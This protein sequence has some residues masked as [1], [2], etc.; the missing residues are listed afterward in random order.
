MQKY[1]VTRLVSLIPTLLLVTILVFLL[2]RLVPGSIV[3]TMLGTEV[4]ASP[5]KYEEMRRFFGLDQ[6]VTIQYFSWMGNVLTGDLGESWRTGESVLDLILSSLQVTALLTIGSMLIALIIGIPFGIISALRENS[7][8]DHVVR[9]VSLLSLSI[10]IFWQAAMI[11]LV[12]SLWLHI[13]PPIGF[14]SPMT[15]PL[16]SLQMMLVPCAVLG[17]GVSATIMRVT[18]SS[19]LDTLREDYVRTARAKG[20]QERAVVWIHV[21]KNAMIPIITIAGLQI[22]QLMGGAIITEEIFTLP[23]IGRLVLWAIYQRDYPVVQ[24]VVL[25]IAVTFALTNLIVDVIYGRIDPRIRYT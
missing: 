19:V 23:G 5:E 25:F 2:T 6:P 1:I 15:D 14:V 3:D 11:I 13:S 20:L 22:G 8:I 12:M 16:E 17:T 4:Q 21:L 10:P 9:V 7:I 24:G 18:R